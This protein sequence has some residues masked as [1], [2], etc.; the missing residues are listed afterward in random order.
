[1]FDKDEKLF[2]G[3]MFI[4]LFCL[5]FTIGG[6]TARAEEIIDYN[7]LLD[8][9]SVVE[10]N[11]RDDAVGDNGKAIGRYQI[12]PSYVDDV[13]R[14]IGDQRYSYEDRKDA[15]C[16]K[17]MVLVYLQHYG[18]RYSRLTGK[19]VTYEV[20]ARIH[21]GGPNGYKKSATLK[22]WRK[23]QVHLLE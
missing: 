3:I 18:A 4:I 19:P 14:L 16:S 7:K 13:N 11:N 9:I 22:Y 2:L 8:A 21:N 10:S 12:W 20:L 15:G 17:I 1:M 6:M 5:A 23:V